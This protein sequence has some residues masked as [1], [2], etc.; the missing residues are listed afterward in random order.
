[1]KGRNQF[2]VFFL[3]VPCFILQN[4]H[5]SRNRY[6]TELSALQG[7]NSKLNFLNSYYD[8]YSMQTFKFL[9]TR[10]DVQFNEKRFFL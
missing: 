1:M 10:Q 3:S 6:T 4:R 9:A 8:K 5:L 2:Q 7:N